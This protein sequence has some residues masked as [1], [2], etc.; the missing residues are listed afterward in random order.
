MNS[1]VS[2][3]REVWDDFID[4]Y[5]EKEPF[6]ASSLLGSEI[7]DRQES[8][9]L[10]V[11]NIDNFLTRKGTGFSLRIFLDARALT[12]SECQLLGVIPDTGDDSFESFLARI[13]PAIG[14]S[15]YCLLVDRSELTPGT[16]DRVYYCLRNIYSR[17]GYI[18]PESLVFFFFG[19]YEKTPF[20]AHYH[21][22]AKECDSSFIFSL[23]GEKK[24]WLWPRGYEEAYPE[25]LGATQVD[26][27]LDDADILEAKPGEMI[28]FPSDMVHVGESQVKDSFNLFLAVKS[29]SDVAN[30]FFGFFSYYVSDYVADSEVH[31]MQEILRA[32]AA[33]YEKSVSEIKQRDRTNSR[34]AFNPTNM[35]ESAHALPEEIRDAGALLTNYVP[36]ALVDLM[37]VKFWLSVLTSYGLV[38]RS[39]S[40]P[41]P[42][43]DVS[44]SI[45]LL[46]NHCV[47]WAR[48]ND[49][50]VISSAGSTWEYSGQSGDVVVEL[51][52]ALNK[53]TRENVGE[54]ISAASSKV[55]SAVSGESSHQDLI[56][57]L[58]QLNSIGVFNVLGDEGRNSMS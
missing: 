53:G 16:R 40:R 58:A 22:N 1:T 46:A 42:R 43:L 33:K 28:Y 32:L 30:A 56:E 31:G 39:I 19:D 17:L 3:N 49:V 44:H 8:F 9:N 47:L 2:N 25:I 55:G 29:D 35:Q 7:M 48:N 23:T 26:Q 11:G 57:I 24:I 51:V 13:Q 38:S 52:E 12:P 45:Q 18:A 21:D 54:L 50:L 15:E 27:F 10:L 5:W 14:D 34:L 20:G 6:V 41:K 4:R 37:C 36:N